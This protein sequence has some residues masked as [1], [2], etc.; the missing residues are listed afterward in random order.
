[1]LF[2][3]YKRPKNWGWD[4][5][6]NIQQNLLTT[7]SLLALVPHGQQLPL[8]K[9]PHSLLPTI[10]FS[11]QPPA[12]CLPRTEVAPWL[13]I[14]SSLSH[15]RFPLTSTWLLHSLSSPPSTPRP[16][17]MLPHRLSGKCS[18]LSPQFFLLT[19][20]PLPRFYTQKASPGADRATQQEP[21]LLEE[22]REGRQAF[23][24]LPYLNRHTLCCVLGLYN[25][26]KGGASS[27]TAVKM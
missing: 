15:P 8:H 2:V 3:F 22:Q 17:F 5:V 14:C 13:T 23:L 26:A 24:F 18:L 10:T 9:S 11:P 7:L 12:Q 19:I 27:Y 1:M 21:F 6:P 20:C 4:S 16:P 25:Y